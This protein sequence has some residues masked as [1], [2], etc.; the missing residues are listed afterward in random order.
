[1]LGMNVCFFNDTATTEIYTLSLHDALPIFDGPYSYGS[2]F[3]AAFYPAALLALGIVGLVALA[4]L[5]FR[6]LAAA[7]RPHTEED[8]AH[9]ERLVHTYGWDTLA[10]FALRDDKTFF[11]SR[12]GEAFVA[13][14][15]LG[16]YA[17]VSG[18]PIGSR[19]SVP[20]VL[21]EFLA[22]CDERAWT[23]ADR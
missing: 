8:W 23:P 7:R 16:G 21:D 14:T 3:F 6:P 9:A 10:Y 22:M 1:M 2:R 17:L 20:R 4:A 19:E 11:F 18:D 5:L 13:Y 12:D 15:Y